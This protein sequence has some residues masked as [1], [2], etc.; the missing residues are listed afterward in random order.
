MLT[1]LNTPCNHP[2][3]KIVVVGGGIS[4][5]ATAYALHERS[6]DANQSNEIVVLEASEAIGGTIAT[7]P[8]NGF[9]CE[10]GPNGFLDSKPH[11]LALIRRLGLSEQVLIA[12]DASRRRFVMVKGRLHELPTTPGA[13]LRSGLLTLG[14]RLR[15][16]CERWVGRAVTAE[17]ETVAA[18]ARRRLGTQAAQRLIDPFVSGVFAGDPEQLSLRATFPRLHELETEYGSLIRASSKLRKERGP[19]E[20]GAAGPGGRLTSFSEGMG[21][22]TNALARALGPCV[23]CKSPVVSVTRDSDRWTVVTAAGAIESVDCVILAIPAYRAAALLAP[24]D[25]ALSEPLNSIPYASVAVV[26]L[27]FHRD[28]VQHPLDGFGFLI[29]HQENRKILGCLWTSSIFPGRRAPDDHVLLRSM[30]GGAR[31]GERVALDDASMVALVR[32][33]LDNLLGLEGDPAL[34]HVRRYDRAIPQYTLGHLDRVEALEEA[35]SQWPGLYVTGNALR[36]VGINDCTREAE[37]VAVRLLD[38]RH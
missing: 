34:V 28:A 26:A 25:K 18:F 23:Q 24:L 6:R 27:G 29:P 10:G 5:L 12:S 19:Q 36:G 21:T 13:F 16:V 4:G 20:G 31:A 37:E 17:D 33:E 3:V 14:G 38:T 2:A 30:V 35:C 1:G 8:S 22:L 7:T 15:V 32:A 11:T 9:L